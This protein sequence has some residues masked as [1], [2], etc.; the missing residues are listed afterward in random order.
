MEKLKCQKYFN[1]LGLKTGIQIHKR[2]IIPCQTSYW[3]RDKMTHESGRPELKLSHLRLYHTSI[4]APAFKGSASCSPIRGTQ[5]AHSPWTLWLSKQS[6]GQRTPHSKACRPV[7]F[8]RPGWLPCPDLLWSMP[9]NSSCCTVRRLR[10][11]DKAG[12]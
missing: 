3:Q 2:R 1:G 10:R 9:R 12:H 4:R 7:S 11:L 6:N 5:Y 8:W